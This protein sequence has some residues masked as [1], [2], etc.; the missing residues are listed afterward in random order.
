MILV[1]FERVTDQIIDNIH[2]QRQIVKLIFFNLIT[3][4]NHIIFTHGRLS[5]SK[6]T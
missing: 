1:G 4:I 6:A 5:L 3:H 2:Y